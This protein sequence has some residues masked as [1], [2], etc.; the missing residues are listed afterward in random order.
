MPYFL[1]TGDFA[2]TIPCLLLSSPPITEGI[3]L[4]ST[5]YP[6]LSNLTAVHDKKALLQSICI[7]ILSFID[8]TI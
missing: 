2:R 3:V 7:T 4:I 6:S 5:G 8:I 1:A